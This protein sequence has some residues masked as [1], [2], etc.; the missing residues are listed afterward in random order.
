MSDLELL[1]MLCRITCLVMA[2]ALLVPACGTRTVYAGGGGGSNKPVKVI[3]IGY[4]TGM[5]EVVNDILMAI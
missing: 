5:Q 1:F 4:L 3:Y 2:V